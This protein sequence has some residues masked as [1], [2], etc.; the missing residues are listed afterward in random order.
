[1]LL[2]TFS[3]AEILSVVHLNNRNTSLEAIKISNCDTVNFKLY[4]MGNSEKVTKN[5]RAP[6][7]KKR[8][9][10]ARQ[11]D[12]EIRELPKGEYIAQIDNY[13]NIL[14]TKKIIILK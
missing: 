14:V 13:S 10:I 1:M 2:G 9:K 11:S 7:P 4:S 6:F 8:K 5:K 3:K 12:F